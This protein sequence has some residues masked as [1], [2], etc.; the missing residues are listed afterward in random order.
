MFRQFEITW[1]TWPISAHHPT[2]HFKHGVPDLPGS[3]AEAPFEGGEDGGVEG[4]REGRYE[5]T[6]KLQ[7]F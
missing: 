1:L 6:V 3:H 5:G 7:A 2:Q 4:V